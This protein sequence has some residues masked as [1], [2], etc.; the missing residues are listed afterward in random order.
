MEK[1]FNPTSKDL[2]LIE[3]L[4]LEIK[5]KKN[6]LIDRKVILQNSL[7]ELRNKY[8]DVDLGSDDYLK[9]KDKRQ[10][11][12]ESLNSLE[13]KIKSLNNELNFKNKLKLEVD[14]HLKHN[15][16][17][18]GKEDL[19]KITN[20]IIT[21]KT[22]YSDFTKDRTRIASLRIMASEFIDELENLFKN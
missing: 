14:F 13:I 16:K 6:K 12:K 9:I 1:E 15:K 21:L 22:K 2:L 20:R 4:I 19:D 11:I 5:T 17:L 10:K 18:E 3:T 8:K 7:S